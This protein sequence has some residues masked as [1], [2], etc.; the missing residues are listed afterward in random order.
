MGEVR[1]LEMIGKTW[2][3][4]SSKH[5]L[6]IYRP[7]L[8]NVWPQKMVEYHV[9]CWASKEWW[10]NPKEEFRR[11]EEK[12]GISLCA[13]KGD[14]DSG[15]NYETHGVTS[16]RSVS[17]SWISNIKNW[18]KVLKDPKMPPNL[19]VQMVSFDIL[20]PSHQSSPVSAV[21]GRQ[22]RRRST[23]QGPWDQGCAVI[24]HGNQKSPNEIE[25]IAAM[26][27][28]YGKI[29]GNFPLPSVMRGYCW[30]QRIW[31]DW[32]VKQQKC[33]SFWRN[34]DIE[35]L[36][37]DAWSILGAAC[38]SVVQLRCRNRSLTFSER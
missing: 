28:I 8:S 22:C 27:A 7:K 6:L 10:K 4:P 15:R 25:V 1:H 3:R 34:I 37:H 26:I 12:D 23:C 2:P 35:K 36:H 14:L 16:R 30:W 33:A 5:R 13:A 24:K 9:W 20:T 17:Q 11:V 31:W 21:P 18:E 29:M 38:V 19:W 32:Q